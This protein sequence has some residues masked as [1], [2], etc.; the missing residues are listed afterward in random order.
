MASD[1]GKQTGRMD[2]AAPGAGPSGD[3]NDAGEES[4]IDPRLDRLIGR[5]LQ[6][7]YADLVSAPLP[8]AIL[9]LLAQLEAREKKS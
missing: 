5:S 2:E 6:A 4:A 9:V 1:F 7:H 3:K 8:D